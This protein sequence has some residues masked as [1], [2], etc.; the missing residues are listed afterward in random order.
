[1]RLPAEARRIL[2]QWIGAHLGKTISNFVLAGLGFLLA[3]L[4]TGLLNRV[5][6][7]VLYLAAL[8]LLWLWLRDDSHPNQGL[9]P[10]SPQNDES[11]PV[12]SDL[13]YT[14]LC[15]ASDKVK[16][17]PEEFG[18]RFSLKGDDLGEALDELSRRGFLTEDLGAYDGSVPN[19]GTWS[20]T[21]EGRKFVKRRRKE[22]GYSN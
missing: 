19:P 9:Q 4:G 20:S 11:N 1:M 10:P 18:N 6:I 22:L 8:S 21:R 7:V 13:A 12:L 5:T 16:L 14:L 2:R 17:D 3:W 15:E